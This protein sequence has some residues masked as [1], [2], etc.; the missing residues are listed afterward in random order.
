MAS[1][2][3]LPIGRSDFDRWLWERNITNIAAG[4][5]LGVAVE[6][7]R[8]YRLPLSDPEYRA[9]RPSTMRRIQDWS[10]GEVGLEAFQPGPGSD[11]SPNVEFIA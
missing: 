6:S 7:V 9:P 2:A 5:E 4:S 1:T 11:P 10:L 3:P 8:R